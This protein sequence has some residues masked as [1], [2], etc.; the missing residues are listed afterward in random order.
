MSYVKQVRAM[1]DLTVKNGQGEM[2][3]HISFADTLGIAIIVLQ[4]LIAI[5]QYLLNRQSK[6]ILAEIRSARPMIKDL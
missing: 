2:M 1:P 6:M 3:E 4:A 5:A